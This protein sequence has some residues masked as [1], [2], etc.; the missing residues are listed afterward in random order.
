MGGVVDI[1]DYRSIRLAEK[2]IG[3]GANF[4]LT[5]LV[6]PSST[7]AEGLN[8]LLSKT[9]LILGVPYSETERSSVILERLVG[10]RFKPN[11]PLVLNYLETIIS[12]YFKAGGKVPSVYISVIGR[13][14]EKRLV[15]FL[16]SLRDIV[17]G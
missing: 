3:V 14:N 16:S 13:F 8:S 10:I 7:I 5:Q 1:T 6:V 4:L 11:P 15:D 2:K 9:R 12:K 17:R